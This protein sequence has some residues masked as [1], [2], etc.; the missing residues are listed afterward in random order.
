MHR[1]KPHSTGSVYW[2]LILAATKSRCGGRGGCVPSGGSPLA[3]GHPPFCRVAGGGFDSRRRVLHWH[4]Y[5]P[6]WDVQRRIELLA[7]LGCFTQAGEVLKSIQGVRIISFS[8][9]G[10]DQSRV[11]PATIAQLSDQTR[12]RTSWGSR[13]ASPSAQACSFH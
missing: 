12:R 5:H 2:S 1:Y 9:P 7:Y 10:C 6:F 4:R 13:Q 8:I 3:P 11:P